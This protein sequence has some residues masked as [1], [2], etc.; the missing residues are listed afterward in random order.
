[1]LFSIMSLSAFAT[2]DKTEKTIELYDSTKSNHKIK[3][4]EVDT[5]FQL[6][7]GQI[8]TKYIFDWEFNP[9]DLQGC[10]YP[11]WRN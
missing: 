1:M 10:P 2:D 3:I 5:E 11:H 7:T 9:A 6:S 8:V 4:T